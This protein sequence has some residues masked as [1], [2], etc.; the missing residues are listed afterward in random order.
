MN[1]PDLRNVDFDAYR[2]RALDLRQQAMNE[3]IDRLWAAIR[4]L[5]AA[6]SH[7]HSSAAQPARSTPCSA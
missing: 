2:Q 7:G 5:P 6:L 4:A 3:L 1:I